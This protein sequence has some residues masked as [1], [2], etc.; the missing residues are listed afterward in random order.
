MS[1]RSHP[2]LT[3][4]RRANV[5]QSVAITPGT[6]KTH[7]VRYL[8][9]RLEQA[10]V[11]VLSGRA[12][13]H[14]GSA[15]TLARR[16]TPSVV[17]LEDVDLVAEDRAVSYG[18]QPML[19]DLLNRI[20]GV[21]ADVDITF[22]LTTNRVETLERALVERPGRIDLAIEVPKPDQAARERLLRLYA[23]EVEL[24]LPDAGE[25]TAR[26]AGVTASFVRE[27]VRRAVFSQLPHT[28]D[29]ARVRLGEASLLAALDELSGERQRLTRSLLGA[30]AG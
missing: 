9:S 13:G 8:L 7:T 11:I 14:L 20:D 1:R 27:L 6:G 29:G 4:Q 12:L 28:P 24:D 18:S 5:L 21:D 19:F 22:V 3:R 15:V 26:M 23:R 2:H 30:P 17:V 25:V 16:L 10:T